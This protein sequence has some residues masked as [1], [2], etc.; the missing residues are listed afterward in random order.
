MYF[1]MRID[2]DRFARA[3]VRAYVEA[4]REEEPELARD[5]ERLLRGVG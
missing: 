5:L 4:C 1:T 3:A 2:T